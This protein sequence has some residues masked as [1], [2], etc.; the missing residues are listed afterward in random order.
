M[1][2]STIAPPT[3][4]T[5][6]LITA[7]LAVLI[8]PASLTG[9]SVAIPQINSELQPGLVEL[10]WV[11][12]AYNLTF[13]AFMLVAG[14]LSDIL[15]R[16]RVFLAGTA[17]FALCSLASIL[18]Q[19]IVLLDL[20]RGASGI[21]AAAMLTAGSALLANAFTGKALAT[22]FAVFGSAA[23]AGLA[24]GPSLSG[25]L[26][27]AFGWRAVFGS[28]LIVSIVVFLLA[29]AVPAGTRITSAA[30]ID[31]AGTVTFT[32]ALFAFV[33]GIMQGPQLGW[34]HPFVLALGAVVVLLGGLFVWVERHSAHPM[35]DFALL[36]N[37]RFF[38][39]CLIPVALAFSFVALLI[40]LPIY[41]TATSA[42]SSAAVGGTMAI[43]TVPVIV[44]PLLAGRLLARGASARWLL[45]ISLLLVGAGAALLTVITPGTPVFALVPPL[46]LIGAGMGLSAGILD[47]AA[48]ASVPPERAGTASGMFNTARLA[49]ETVGIAVVGTVLVALVY[50][51]LRTA[52]PGSD[53]VEAANQA[54]SGNIAGIADGNED[55]FSALASAFTDAFHLMLWGM[56]VL[57]V[58]TAAATLI[59]MRRPRS[60][61]TTAVADD[62][63]SSE[64]TVA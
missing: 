56:T 40:Y 39:L 33:L 45:A 38:T 49:G 5:L 31:W 13:A 18:T 22:A 8:L 27:G 64:S 44:V 9:T 62:T 25:L 15:G 36:R 32:P 43:L 2:S 1:T 11:V 26:V 50:S 60:A 17:V 46:V 37:P 6:T 21:G 7:C 57:A 28:H 14:S 24:I 3:R 51:T 35:F 12:N 34:T 61:G 53:A 16:K 19:D 30:R 10:Q 29:L 4:Q 55:I 41:L 52:L 42:L 63:A 48:V 47:G 20:A 23:G 59:I 54:L 58:A